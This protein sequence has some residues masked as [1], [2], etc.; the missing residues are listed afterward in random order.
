MAEVWRCDRVNDRITYVNQ[1]KHVNELIL[2]AQTDFFKSRI[3]SAFSKVLFGIVKVY[4]IDLN[5]LPVYEYASD[6]ATKF[7]V[8]LN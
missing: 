3:T 5:S 1:V 6:L 8:S 7:A 4:L 2:L